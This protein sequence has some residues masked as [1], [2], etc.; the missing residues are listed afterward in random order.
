MS[1]HNHYISANLV[2]AL[3]EYFDLLKLERH[4]K[5]DKPTYVDIGE[6]Q[7]AFNTRAQVT[8]HRKIAEEYLRGFTNV[9][10]ND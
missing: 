9:L 1:E 10:R 5:E 7:M 4:W 3:A 6:T 8:S 2:K